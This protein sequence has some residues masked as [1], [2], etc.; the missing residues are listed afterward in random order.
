MTFD[1]TEIILALITLAVAA[2]TTFLIPWI[3]SKTTA[4]QRKQLL[5]WA[6]IGV[7][8]AEVLYK[9]SGRGEEKFAYVQKWLED[10]GVTFDK[11]TITNAI[12]DA[13]IWFKNSATII[14]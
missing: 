10:Q 6:K 2:I 5:E 1:V 9:G 3:K 8:A 14:S 12:E 4:E 11:T 7:S 13:L